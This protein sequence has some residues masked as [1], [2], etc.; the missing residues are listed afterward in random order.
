MAALSYISELEAKRQLTGDLEPAITR[1]G[2]VGEEP[3]R[4]STQPEVMRVVEGHC[5][6]SHKIAAPTMAVIWASTRERTPDG[7]FLVQPA[8]AP[9]E[10]DSSQVQRRDE[11]NT[12]GKPKETVVDVD[13]TVM[14]TDLA[15]GVQRRE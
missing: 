13:A 4:R 15:G 6:R 10:L 7:I 1:I 8:S 9:R 14:R 3:S 12:E 11:P 5:G 2:W